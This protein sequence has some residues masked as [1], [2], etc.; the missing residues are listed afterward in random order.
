KPY[1]TADLCN[2]LQTN[3]DPATPPLTISVA[4]G[5]TLQQLTDAANH[6]RVVR[7]MPNTPS[8]VGGG[9]SGYCVAEGVA[10]A[11]VDWVQRV[12]ES[13]GVAMHVSESQ[14]NAVTG[15]SGSG[16]AYVFMIIEALADGGVAAGLRREQAMQL[17]CSVVGGAAKMVAQTQ[18]HPGQLKDN[19]CSPGGTTIE[20]IASLEQSG[21]RSALIEAVLTAKRRAD[22][23]DA[24]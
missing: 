21:L 24:E 15:L 19:V 2:A 18:Q 11:D 4:A 12:L 6:Q 5:V 20:A 16:P 9:A 13:V 7:V 1:Q 10:A 22:A 3:I 8:L 14:M 23:M 17:A